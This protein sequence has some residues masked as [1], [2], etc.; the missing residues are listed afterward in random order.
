[1]RQQNKTRILVALLGTALLAAVV[2]GCGGSDHNG[3][4][5]SSQ[6]MANEVDRAFVRLMVPHHESAIA[7]AKLADSKGQ[8]KQIK[9]LAMDINATQNA[10]IDQMNGIAK[11]IGTEVGGGSSMSGMDHS[12]AHAMGDAADF[13]TLG[14]TQETAGMSMDMTRLENAKPFDRAF[15]DMMVLHHKGAVRMAKAELA[16]GENSSL[17]SIARKIVAAQEREIKEM[18]SWRTS[19]YGGPVPSST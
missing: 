15:I 14:L 4:G 16:K 5:G 19:W 9:T 1:M 10:E 3:H 17:Q 6:A 11:T 7:M 8:H 12:G 13:K 18:N 2:A